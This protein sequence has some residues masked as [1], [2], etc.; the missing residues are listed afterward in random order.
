[1]AQ[2]SNRQGSATLP[3]AAAAAAGGCEPVQSGA[4]QPSS[5]AAGGK[6]QRQQ[7][8]QSQFITQQHSSAGPAGAAG[9]EGAAAKPAA[10]TTSEAALH[11]VAFSTGQV[12][13]MH[14]QV[15][16][17]LWYETD[18]ESNY[19][20]QVQ[21][22]VGQ[23][24]SADAFLVKLLDTIGDAA[25]KLLKTTSGIGVER[26]HQRRLRK[27]RLYVLKVGRLFQ[28]LPPEKR[29]VTTEADLNER[30]QAELHQEGE[31][32]KQLAQTLNIVQCFGFGTA[33]VDAARMSAAAA[34]APTSAAAAL[35]AAASAD[36]DPL[37]SQHPC[38][39]LEYAAGG[40]LAQTLQPTAGQYMPMNQQEAAKVMRNVRYALQRMHELGF[41]YGDLQPG[42][43]VSARLPGS[44]K[45]E[46]HLLDLASMVQLNGKDFTPHQEC[47]TAAYRAPEQR[48]GHK[49][50][51][52]AD[53]Y[54]LGMLL[55]QL[56]TGACVREWQWF[57]FLREMHAGAVDLCCLLVVVLQQ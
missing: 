25:G 43:V 41:V 34:A 14:P 47:G 45:F 7:N 35:T 49:F 23:G 56:R 5:A 33:K 18:T 37:R 1:V 16:Q 31:W 27:G 32:Y 15:S 28:S 21:G 38:L 6:Q 10:A 53:V 24:G 8:Q 20:F 26:R 40:S 57:F 55:L 42:N 2:T 11:E 36:G 46:W 51:R 3:Q 48:E 39:L 50:N 22:L 17:F 29:A 54:S 4:T 12:V 19:Y 30:Q 13:Q 44:Q 52:L 9:V